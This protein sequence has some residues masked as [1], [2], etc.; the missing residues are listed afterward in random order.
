M[1]QWLNSLSP[2]GLRERRSKRHWHEDRKAL[3]EFN[4]SVMLIA[5][6][7]SLMPSITAR[8]KEIFGTDRIAILRA[9]ARENTFSVAY[10]AGWPAKHLA[11][12]HLLQRGRLTK[13]LRA[14]ETPLVIREDCEAFNDLSPAEREMLTR[15]GVRVCVPLLALNRLT[16]M[17][18]LSST[19]EELDFDSDDL[20]LLQMLMSQA[21]IALENGYLYQE[22]RG[23]LSRL[24]RAEKLAAAGQ[25]AASVA[26][27]IRNPLTTIRSTV[28]YLISCFEHDAAKRKLIEGVIS[29]VDRI[30]Q[31]VSSL[32]NLTRS[33]AIEPERVALGHLIHEAILMAQVQG[34]NQS[35]DIVWSPLETEVHIMGDPSQLK[36]LLLNL[37]LNAFQ[38]MPSGGRLSIKLQSKSDPLTEKKWAVVS[39]TDTGCGIPADKIERVLDPFFTTKAGGTGLGLSTSYAIA[40]EH[41][42]Q[43]EINSREREGTRVTLK[44]PLVR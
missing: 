20:S 9:H 28:Q 32:L 38:A 16:G 13:W 12:L 21:S 41:G 35:V 11:D 39:L 27:E 5:D 34:Q 8:V 26:H 1:P 30:N 6:P 24:Y 23:R 15:L 37:M 25:L 14:N 31:T 17:M 42:G 19:E 18:L 4:R 10:C 2:K 44:F 3:L 7:Q 43:L 29:E 22:Q 40:H 33:N 36:Q